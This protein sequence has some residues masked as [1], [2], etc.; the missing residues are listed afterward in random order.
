MH[1]PGIPDVPDHDPDRD[2][3]SVRVQDLPASKI[4]ILVAGISGRGVKHF[5]ARRPDAKDIIHRPS[6]NPAFI[7]IPAK[8]KKFPV[9][10]HY[11]SRGILAGFC[12]AFIPEKQS[13]GLV[14]VLSMTRTML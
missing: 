8:G 4:H 6:Q 1:S 11:P 9:R 14:P 5:R 10:A 2:T 7:C 12:G 13:G 3:G